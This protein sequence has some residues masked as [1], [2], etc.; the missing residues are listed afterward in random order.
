MAKR[1]CRQTGTR[2][3]RS[4]A[5]ERQWRDVL[6]R[7]A[8]SGLTQSAFCRQQELSRAS[9]GWWKRELARRD[10]EARPS[11]TGQA[12]L[13]FIPLQVKAASAAIDSRRCAR[14]EVVLGGHRRVRVDGDFDEG[15]LT[16]VVRV[17]EAIP[18]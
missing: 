7:W 18:C 14:I 17:L 12:A 4:A 5:L 13:S 6:A 11:T 15:V 16:K 9:F 2:G 1:T 10:A 8:D 3:G